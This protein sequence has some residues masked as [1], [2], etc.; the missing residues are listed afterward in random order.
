MLYER[1]AL[2]KK[3]DK[4]IATEWKKLRDEDRLTPDLVLRDASTQ[5]VCLLAYKA[6]S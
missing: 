2:S 1:T 6:K 4:S 5:R 3:P